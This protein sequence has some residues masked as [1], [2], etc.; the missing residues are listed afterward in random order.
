VWL[1][2]LINLAGKL[3]AAIVV[4]AAPW[5]ALALWVVPDA[6]TLYHV[7]VF[8]AQGVV[9]MHRRF[10]TAER[11][12]WL[13]IDDGPD[14]DDTPRILELL[15]KHRA[16][17]TFFVIGEN[18]IAYPGLVRAIVEAGHEVAHHTQ[19]H[20]LHTFWC[21]SPQRLRRELDQGLAAL[22]AE[23]VRP[24]R[25][26]PPAGLKNLWLGRALAKRALTCVGWSARGL[27]R[28]GGD[29]S[30]VVRRV[31]RDLAPGAILLLHEGPSVPRAIRVHAIAGVLDRIQELGFRCVVPTA[32]ELEGVR[33]HARQRATTNPVPIVSAS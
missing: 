29:A 1:L 15:A 14:P 30:S 31:T 32:G 12:V 13:T 20:P 16:R 27:E 2:I 24:V 23:G 22:A 7:L 3:S 5:T 28:S 4:G 11:E 9:L 18:V 17:A 33:S 26:R 19:T 8:R 10:A 6:L 25:F 21:A